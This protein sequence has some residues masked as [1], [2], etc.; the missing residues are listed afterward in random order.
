[1]S[2]GT[3]EIPDVAFQNPYFETKQKW[4]ARVVKDGII[5]DK[6]YFYVH[7]ERNII[8]T[9]AKFLL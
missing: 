8:R 7:S 4:R 3:T 1:M 9:P 6:F 2:E 5:S